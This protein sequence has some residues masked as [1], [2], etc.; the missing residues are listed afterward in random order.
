MSHLFHKENH[1][2]ILQCKQS[3][4]ISKWQS[5]A[6]NRSRLDNCQK[7]IIGQTVIHNTQLRRRRFQSAKSKHSKRVSDMMKTVA[8]SR[9]RSFVTFDEVVLYHG[10]TTLIH[11]FYLF[12]SSVLLRIMILGDYICL[13][14]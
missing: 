6:V 10:C 12:P 2:F 11:H 3:L 7:E 14:Y 13:V 1:I 9:W 5:E 8:N 4:N